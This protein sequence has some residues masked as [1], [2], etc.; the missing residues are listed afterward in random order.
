MDIGLQEGNVSH[1]LDEKNINKVEVRN[2]D[3]DWT[4]VCQRGLDF[5]DV[6]VKR[7]WTLKG[8]LPDENWIWRMDYQTIID[9]KM[10]YQME[11][12]KKIKFPNG[13]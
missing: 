9:F 13:N 1:G 7:S 5:W 10:D 3:E 6:H 11:L 2:V 4:L 12:V 8:G